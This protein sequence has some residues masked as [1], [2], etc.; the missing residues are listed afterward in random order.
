MAI[1]SGLYFRR[2]VRTGLSIL[3]GA[4]SICGIAMAQTPVTSGSPI[5]TTHATWGQIMKVSVAKNGSVVFLD[6]SSSGLYQLRPGASTFTTIATGAPNG[7]LEASG[8]YWNSGMTMDAK[9][10]IYLADRYGSSHFF[11]IP[12]N[13]ADGTWDFTSSNA[14]GATIGNGDVSL[15]TYDVAFIDST[16]KDGSGSLVVST[17]TSNEIYT[18]PVDK[19]GAWGS[20]TVIVKGLKGRATHIAADVNGNIYFTEDEGTGPTGRVTGVFFVPTGKNGI[21]GAGDGSA[22]AQLSRIDP[23]S[24]QDQFSGITLDAAGNIYLSSQ[25]DG[26]GGAFNG[27]LM[28]PNISG[29]PLNVSLSS[30][31]FNS[32]TFITPVQTSSTLAIDPRGYFW[33]PTSTSGWTPPG[34]LAFPGTNNVVLWQMG[35]ASVGASPVGKTGTPGIV[36]FN[37][38]QSITPGSLAFTQAGTGSD[39]VASAT[40]P[41]TDPS[42]TTPQLPCT[43]GKQYAAYTSCPYF[44]ALN[45][46][47]PGAISGKVAMYDSANKVIPASTTYLYGIGQGADIS[48]LV[49]ASQSVIGNGLSSPQQVAAD[50]LGNAYVADSKLGQV[51]KYAAGS[52]STSAGVSVGTGLTAPTGVAVDGTGDVYIA[53]SGNVYEVPFVNGALNAA[54]QV[55]LASGLG[56]NLKLATD[57]AGN[58]FVADPDNARVLRIPNPL[59]QIVFPGHSTIGSGFTRPSAIA[60]DN[61]GN[62]F[63][64]DGSTLFEIT[65]TFDG[66]PTAIT[67]SLAAPVT[68]LAADPSGSVNVAQA[69]GILH[70]PSLAG[71]LSTNSAVTIAPAIAAPN[72]LAIDS[73]G[74]LYVA[75]LTTPAT[76]NLLLLSL[77]ATVDLGQVSPFVP[78]NPVD[79]NVYN[80]GNLPLT[81]MPDPTFSGT[82]G[83]DFSTTLPT[84]NACDTTGMTS[85]APGSAC[86]IDPVA[87]ASDVGTRSGTMTITSNAVNEPSATVSLT[88]VG[89]NNLERSKVTMVVSPTTGVAYPGATNVTVTVAPTVSTT[90]PTGQVILVLV[91][92]K[93]RQATTYPTGTLVNG[94]V[95]FNLQNILGGTYTVKATYHGDSNFSGGVVTTTLVVAQAAPTVTLSQPK[96]ITALLGVYYVPVGSNT[97]LSASVASKQGTPTGSIRFMNG[98]ALADPAQ[99]AVTLDANGNATFSTQNLPAGTYNLTAVYSGDQ[100][101]STITSPLITFLVIPKSLLITANPASLTVTAGTP[102][103]TVLTLT[104]LVGFEANAKTGGVYIACDNTTVPKYSE[105]TFDVPQVQVLA[106]SSSNTTLTLSSNLPVNV[107]L[108]K[109]GPSTIAF[110]GLFGAGLLGLAFRRR[111]SR[112][113]SAMTT[114]CL[115]LLLS[116]VACGVSGCT[117]AGYTTTP[118]APHVVTPAGTYNIRLYATDP[119]DGSTKTLPFTLPVTVK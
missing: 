84:Q 13:P 119:T 18:V 37:F 116:G 118:P 52:T 45:A 73:A 86:I 7:P 75:D 101:F 98:S 97:T 61:N 59:S 10:T 1:E 107:G 92:A 28:V 94:V 24:N 57:G 110:A 60:T 87:T 68:G 5:P 79:V 104:S 22:E 41:I 8:T 25:S 9:D 30:F 111:L 16:A 23:T 109:Q 21:S 67:N 99:S 43:P 64:A 26:N 88:A 81:I 65:A 103:Q 114:F 66:A 58:V 90:V 36:Y 32:A 11:R 96:G 12:Y 49:P 40:N 20:P 80:I 78:S 15:Q 44:V 93:Q 19:T 85:V 47:L 62:I 3:F 108:L 42:A 50:S 74:N 82:N 2:L 106:G 35:S 31:D 55:K 102:V 53:D 76:P 6:W 115:M 34:S 105:C 46:R 29:S 54:G 48:L 4:L 112:Y 69:G 83:A 72:G 77:N 100:N 95:T 63:V 38:S 17:E 14:W 113:R 27:D 56:T 51:Y 117:N 70:I 39:F 33:I 91:N 71:V 89:V